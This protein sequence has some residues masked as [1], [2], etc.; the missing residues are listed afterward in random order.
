MPQTDKAEPRSKDFETAAFFTFL[1]RDCGYLEPRELGDGRY[2]A[3]LPLL[4]THAIITGR[5]GDVL[6]YSDRWC[7]AGFEKARAALDAWDGA[8]EPEGWHR[9][10]DTGRRREL[11]P[12][13]GEILS[14]T[15]NP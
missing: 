1:I 6:G 15:I 2:A 3:I 11:D 10:P 7:Y 9:H 13:T 5:M 4:F 14:E 8:G 12:E